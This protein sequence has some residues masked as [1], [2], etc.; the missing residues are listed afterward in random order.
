[1]D[2]LRM[3][4]VCSALLSGADARAHAQCCQV[5]G[6]LIVMR[7]RGRQLISLLSAHPP[8]TNTR[9][10]TQN[11]STRLQISISGSSASNNSSTQLTEE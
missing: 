2:Y 6:Q 4:D 9:T 1:M 3:P 11:R 8:P 5:G 7:L 10:H